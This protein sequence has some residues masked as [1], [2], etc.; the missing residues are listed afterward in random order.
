MID[1]HLPDHKTR[2]KCITASCS[3]WVVNIS[4]MCT[5]SYH[6]MHS[7]HTCVI[8][9]WVG[10]LLSEASSWSY[11]QGKQDELWRQIAQATLLVSPHV[12]VKFPP[13]RDPCILRPRLHPTRQHNLATCACGLPL[14]KM[15]AAATSDS[16][17]K[18][19]INFTTLT[20]AVIPSYDPCKWL[21][22][23]VWLIMHVYEP[24][25]AHSRK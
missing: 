18:T 4:L 9:S 20:C 23:C 1:L 14:F 25:R 8:R 6:S 17:R 10:L 16:G 15:C 21:R 13:S 12:Q 7:A 24:F 11:L 19:S 2:R 5:F 3:S 22:S